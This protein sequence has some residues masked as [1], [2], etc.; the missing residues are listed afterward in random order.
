MHVARAAFNRSRGYGS[1]R[2][3]LLSLDLEPCLVKGHSCQQAADL[4]CELLPYG[5]RGI[6]SAP[7]AVWH[8]QVLLDRRQ[9]FGEGLG[10]VFPSY[11][12]LAE[13]VGQE[14]AEEGDARDDQRGCLGPG[15]AAVCRL[16]PR[17][18]AHV[19]PWDAVRC[20]LHQPLAAGLT[21][22]E[23]PVVLEEQVCADNLDEVQKSFRTRPPPLFRVERYQRQRASSNESRW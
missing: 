16:S 8:L 21:A 19:T 20:I 6:R 18:P 1:P 5:G 9:R 3:I 14:G 2:F 4:V 7:Y 10:S 13:G 15:P 11:D 12:P 23:P 17:W 22:G